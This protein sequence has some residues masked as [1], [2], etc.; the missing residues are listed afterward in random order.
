MQ[1]QLQEQGK[2]LIFFNIT[3][4]N[5]DVMEMKEDTIA[6]E[7]VTGWQEKEKMVPV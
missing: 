7:V 1:Y 5:S 2:E 4:K 6:A 3:V